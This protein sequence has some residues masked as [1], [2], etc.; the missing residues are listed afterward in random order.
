MS[1]TVKFFDSGGHEL[2]TRQFQPNQRI[3][4]NVYGT[5]MAGIPEPFSNVA[6]DIYNGTVNLFSRRN[7]TNLWGIVD[8]PVTFPSNV[9]GS[10]NVHV[11]IQYPASGG[12]TVDIPIA[13]GNA[14]PNPLPQQTDWLTM[15]RNNLLIISAIAIGGYFIVKKK[16]F[17]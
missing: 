13:F 5:G 11:S 4:V 17:R 7:T 8:F 9:S 3:V 2:S 15:L 1:L 10:G 14:Q 12:D 16:L 6:V